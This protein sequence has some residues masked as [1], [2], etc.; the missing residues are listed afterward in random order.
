MVTGGLGAPIGLER[1]NYLR[2][3]VLADID[4]ATRIA[5]A[6][7][8]GPVLVV[9]PYEDEDEDGA[10]RIADDSPNGL[11]GGVWTRT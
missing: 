8:L 2:P 6:E 4:S 9:I 7:I 11:S 1:G 5:R 10:V 3:N